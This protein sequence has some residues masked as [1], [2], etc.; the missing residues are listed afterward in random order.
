MINFKSVIAVIALVSSMASSNAGA[1][2]SDSFVEIDSWQKQPTLP[3]PLSNHQARVF[4]DWLVVSGGRDRLGKPVAQMLSAKIRGNGA[5]ESWKI[6][7]PF[8]F[9]ISGHAMESLNGFAYISGGMRQSGKSESLTPAVWMSQLAKDGY[10]GKWRL[11]RD[12]PEGLQAHNMVAWGNSLYVIAGMS[13]DG[14]SNSVYK[15]NQDKDGRITS[16]KQL[17]SLPSA[18]A[19]SSAVVL[20]GYLVVVGGQSPAEGKTL[21]MPTTYVGPLMKD[22]EPTTWY[23]ASSKL[24]GAWLGFGRCQAGLIAYRNTLLCFGGQDSSWFYINNIASTSFDPEKGEI[25]K[26]G[27]SDGPKDMAQV[28][29]VSQWKDRVYM[30]GGFSG[31]KITAQVNSLKLGTIAREEPR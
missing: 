5:L 16:W 23:L 11:T 29:A 4:G 2:I 30:V 22:G 18:L 12:M 9:P 31:G 1:S 8:P 7:A 20:N 21:I 25:E 14:F 24:P 10:P 28:S 6:E 27:I 17:L 19:Y 26:W 15:G 13:K 3:F